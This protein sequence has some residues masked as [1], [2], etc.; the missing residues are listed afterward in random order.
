MVEAA[1]ELLDDAERRQ[2]L[3]EQAR[4]HAQRHTWDAAVDAWEQLLSELTAREG[5]VLPRDRAV[6]SA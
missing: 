3:G 4:Q 5:D 1:S 6:A 2:A